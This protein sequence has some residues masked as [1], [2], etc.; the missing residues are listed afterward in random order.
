MYLRKYI[1]SFI[2]AIFIT[3]CANHINEL[4]EINPNLE[5][6][7]DDLKNDSDFNYGDNILYSYN[8][9]LR[10]DHL[11][12]KNA[13]YKTLWKHAIF[14]MDFEHPKHLPLQKNIKIYNKQ[15]EKQLKNGHLYLY[16]IINLLKTKK[17]PLELVVIP[18]IESNFNPHAT[19]PAGAVGL[20]QFVKIT[21]KRF[22]LKNTN[23]YD[24]RK[25]II[26]STNA[27]LNYFEYLYKLFNDW[28]L[29]IAAYNVGE[30]TVLK[31]IKQNKA[32]G[33]S[34]NLWSLNIPKSGKQYV[35]KLYSYI[36]ILR[37]ARKYNI[38]F[39]GMSYRPVFTI[40]PINQPI[41]V[42]EISKKSGISPERILKLNP[43]FK[44]KSAKTSDAPYILLPIQ[45]RDIYENYIIW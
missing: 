8:S 26:L 23:T 32:K 20:W 22:N 34:I 42:N 31:A 41:S 15:I 3:G 39:P 18:I 21:A 45:N 10:E 25:D 40:V 13:T 6:S 19:S 44:S 11:L 24:Q 27:A 5:A 28:D 33:K 29:A 12:I 14:E 9:I 17:M 43:G 2:I 36:N 1:L 16:Y 35:E 30:G 38:I 4:N 37:N 7:V